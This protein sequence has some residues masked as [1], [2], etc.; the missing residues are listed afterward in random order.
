MKS[1]IV[2]FLMMFF[3]GAT[4]GSQLYKQNP[5]Q[6]IDAKVQS[7]LSYNNTNYQDLEKKSTELNRPFIERAVY[8]LSSTAIFAVFET[9]REGIRYGFAHPETNYRGMAKF[10][11]LCLL[12]GAALTLFVPLLY[13]IATIYLLYQLVTK[14]KEGKR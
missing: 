3:V 5:E 6:D 10:I 8:K 2:I 9:A 7:V 1:F 11:L 13:A 14:T 12:L 4:V